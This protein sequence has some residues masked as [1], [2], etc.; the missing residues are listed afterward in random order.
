MGFST[1]IELNHDLEFE[2]EQDPQ[3]FVEHILSRLRSGYQAEQPLVGGIFVATIS[4]YETVYG[5]WEKFKRNV[6]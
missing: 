5:A 1:I 2:I 3:L 4:R 6:L